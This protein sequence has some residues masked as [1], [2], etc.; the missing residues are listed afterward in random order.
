MKVYTNGQHFYHD[1]ETP[2]IWCSDGSHDLRNCHYRKVKNKDIIKC[3]YKECDFTMPASLILHLPIVSV[4]SK[5]YVYLGNGDYGDYP[6]DLQE[7][8]L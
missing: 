5:N 7:I 6:D 2:R 3:F 4:R 8:E 1:C